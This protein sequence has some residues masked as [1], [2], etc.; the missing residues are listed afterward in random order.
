MLAVQENYDSASSPKLVRNVWLSIAED[1]LDRCQLQFRSSKRHA[2]E[3]GHG[4]SRSSRPATSASARRTA[5]MASSA[6]T[7]P[8]WW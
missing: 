6:P 4:R 3:E 8:R 1:D 2:V 7:S 5:A